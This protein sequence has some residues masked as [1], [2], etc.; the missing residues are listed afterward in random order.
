[1]TRYIIKGT[2][3]SGIHAGKN[4]YLIRGGNVVDPENGVLIYDT[5]SLSTCKAVCAKKTK[6]NIWQHDFEKREREQREKEGKPQFLKYPLY[7]L[8]SYEPFAIEYA[9]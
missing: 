3:Q 5:Y 7:E 8:E 1:M 4:F 2:Y 6:D 9:E